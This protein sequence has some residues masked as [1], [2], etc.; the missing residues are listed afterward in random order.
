MFPAALLPGGQWGAHRRDSVTPISLWP[1]AGPVPAPL[2]LRTV[3]GEHPRCSRNVRQGRDWD[4]R[5]LRLF[6]QSASW[7]V[8]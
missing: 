3:S 6:G 5:P 4:S 8:S 7:N 2:P 1:R